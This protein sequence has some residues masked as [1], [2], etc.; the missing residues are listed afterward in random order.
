MLKIWKSLGCP[1]LNKYIGRACNSVF[2]GDTRFPLE[3]LGG[4]LKK[5]LALATDRGPRNEGSRIS[6]RSCKDLRPANTSYDHGA[7]RAGKRVPTITQG[8]LHPDDLE[9]IVWRLSR[10][11]A[12]CSNGTHTTPSTAIPVRTAVRA[13]QTIRYR[14][15]DQRRNGRQGVFYGSESG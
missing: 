15:S 7:R 6:D 13:E 10:I 1:F 9:N 5:V 4:C 12:D 14:Q 3:R 8:G 2:G 11:V